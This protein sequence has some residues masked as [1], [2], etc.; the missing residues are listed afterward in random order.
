MNKQPEFYVGYQAKSPPGLA[1]R[2]RIV[3]V[4]LLFAAVAVA[5]SVLMLEKP[6]EPGVFEFGVVKEFEGILR[7]NPIPMLLEAEVLGDTTP[8]TPTSEFLLVSPGKRTALPLVE[9]FDGQRV[10]LEGSLIYRNQIAMI[11]VRPESVRSSQIETL[12]PFSLPDSTTVGDGEL[13]GEIVDAKCFLG[14]MKPGREKTH[15]SCAARCISGGIPPLLATSTVDGEEI[16]YLLLDSN[17]SAVNDRVLDFVA[18]PVAI[19]GEIRKQGRHLY[20]LAD[21]ESIRRTSE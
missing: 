21:L 20:L 14:V 15:R 19:R 8:S 13:A 12:R 17:G 6:F 4:S 3:V 10:H 2:T 16:F 5:L 1:R 9:G 11:E 7:A 18:E